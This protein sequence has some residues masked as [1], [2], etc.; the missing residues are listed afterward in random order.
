[1]FNSYDSCH[2]LL[3]VLGEDIFDC[4]ACD[5]Q[6]TNSD[7]IRSLHI[8]PR[9]SDQPT[10]VGFKHPDASF[11]GVWLFI[12]ASTVDGNFY[13][14]GNRLQVEIEG[15]LAFVGTRGA[16]L[17]T[18]CAYQ[19]NP[20]LDD[21]YNALAARALNRVIILCT[22]TKTAGWT[23]KTDRKWVIVTYE[24]SRGALCAVMSKFTKANN[25]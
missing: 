23:T 4:V 18:P 1:M 17:W 6:W 13:M 12:G 20:N 7:R 22:S 14:M 19:I 24:E 16:R 8:E 21:I 5:T 15:I 11:G 10:L 3:P 9:I 25:A 2:F